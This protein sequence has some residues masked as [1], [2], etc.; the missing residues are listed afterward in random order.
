MDGQI[1]Y[2][3]K[4][5]RMFGGE[6]VHWALWY[7]GRTSMQCRW[8][9]RFP[10]L[11]A[12]LLAHMLTSIDACIHPCIPA[13]LTTYLSTHQGGWAFLGYK[14]RQCFLSWMFVTRGSPACSEAE[15]RGRE[16]RTGN[17]G[18]ISCPCTRCW[19]HHSSPSQGETGEMFWNVE[20]HELLFSKMMEYQSFFCLFCCW[21]CWRTAPTG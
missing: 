14:T 15:Y 17:N 3:Q 11:L 13:Y 12:Y 19:L 9:I 16:L 21:A 8:W 1:P 7:R 18:R 5:Y 10:C 2:K 4:L 6:I 20:T